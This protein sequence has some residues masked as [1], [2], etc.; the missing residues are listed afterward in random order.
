MRLLPAGSFVVRMDQPHSRVADALLDRQYWSPDDPQ[1]HPYDDT[2]WS[3]G[4]LF[5]VEALRVVDGKIL[6]AAM[7]P[8]IGP[9]RPPA[10]V[11]GTG[12]V[13]LVP[14]RGA[15]AMLPLRYALG[16]SGSGVRV[17]AAT[18]PFRVLAREFPR[19][20]WI[21]SD[22]DREVLTEIST[23]LGIAVLAT[24]ERPAV[25][26]RPVARPRLAL[27]HSWLNTQTEGWWR[28]RLDLL[29]AP[30]DY[31][32]T[33]DV[34]VTPDL[35]AKYDV[36]LFPPVGVGEPQRI[37]TGLP[38]YGGPL[39]WLTT[40]ETPNLGTIDATADQRPGLGFA[41]LEH[42]RR[43][44]EAGGLLVA[45]EDTA[46]LLIA[47]GLT[48]G[49]RVT[50]TDDLR[51]AGS[52]LDARFP[53]T[54]SPVTE[55]FGDRLSV[56]SAEGMS[57]ELSRLASGGFASDDAAGRPTGRGSKSDTDTPQ[58]RDFPAAAAPPKAERW[59]S[60]PLTREQTRRNPNVIPEALLPRALVRFGDAGELLVS[61]LLD[62][63]S[64]LARRA[65]V[66]DVPV[67]K[68]HILLFAINPIWRGSTVGSHPLVWNAILAYDRLAPEPR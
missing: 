38:M 58:G 18:A 4:E 33:Q 66:V 27:L 12:A 3:F 67:G 7:D 39:P 15:D 60:L 37:V 14:N 52:I 65:A 50:D 62:H 21:V 13:F 45:V 28:Q 44:V 61:G 1:T 10:G 8:V 53:P 56:Y 63:G 23:R 64:E 42:L 49:V 46:S 20:S 34:A 17:E 24:V 59:E 9:V 2:G 43:F 25:A 40:P 6:A 30:Y 51:V 32:S 31:I 55:G 35:A 57:F 36:I 11:S 29:G 22:V 68:G 19:G 26:T 54:A 41:G 16:D 48:P 47:N 5:D